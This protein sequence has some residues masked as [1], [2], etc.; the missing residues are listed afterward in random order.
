MAPLAATQVRSRRMPWPPSLRLLTR[1]RSG[2]P[3]PWN[4]SSSSRLRWSIAAK[5][6][7][8]RPHGSGRSAVRAGRGAPLESEQQPVSSVRAAPSSCPC[9][10][11]NGQLRSTRERADSGGEGV[12]EFKAELEGI[13]R[14]LQSQEDIFVNRFL[15]VCECFIA[16]RCED[17]SDVL[18]KKLSA[19][20]SRSRLS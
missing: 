16:V 20:N 4:R 1:P 18:E 10:G 13:E 5:R 9:W 15:A 12:R 19:R 14:K 17:H 11:S 8:E 3:R 7:A 2:L 6:A